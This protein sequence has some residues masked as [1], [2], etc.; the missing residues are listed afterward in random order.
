MLGEPEAFVAESFGVLRE[1]E[2]LPQRI[3]RL[4]AARY[5]REIEYGDLRHAA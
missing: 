3:G 2:A 4:G 5:E 1:I